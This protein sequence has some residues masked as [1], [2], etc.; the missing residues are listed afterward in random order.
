LLM[1]KLAISEL[2]CLWR[3]SSGPEVQNW[4]FDPKF[5][6][7]G[8]AMHNTLPE[9]HINIRNHLHGNININVTRIGIGY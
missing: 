1:G 7:N 2:F 5:F 6:K 9:T 4:S 3:V 8:P